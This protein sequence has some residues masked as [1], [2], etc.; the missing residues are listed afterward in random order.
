[1]VTAF[2]ELILP[3]LVYLAIMF[4][5]IWGLRGKGD[6]P[7]VLYLV[8]LAFPQIA[9]AANELPL[10]STSLSLL[11]ISSLFAAWMVKGDVPPGGASK[12]IVITYLAYVTF[13]F[14]L[15]TSV[16]GYTEIF[17]TRAWVFES[18]RNWMLTVLL[19]FVG[20]RV[21]RSDKQLSTLF[22]ILAVAL[23][24]L[25][26]REFRNFYGGSTFSYLK[27]AGETFNLRG[28]N[29]NHFAAF[30]AYLC[31]LM[32]GLFVEDKRLGRRI[33]YLAAAGA[34]LY[35]L[36]FSYSRGAYAALALAIFAVGIL[37]YRPL[38]AYGLV[39]AIFWQAI[40]PES[41]VDRVT[42]TESPDGELEESAALRLVVWN[43][44]EDVFLANPIVG[45]GFQGFFFASADLPLH[46]A[47][48]YFLQT[49]A[50]QGAIGVILLLVILL[51][52][53]WVGLTLAR[54]GETEI[55]RGLG[56]GFF[57]LTVAMATA[58]IFGDRF[59]LMEMGSYFW[60]LFGASQRLLN[61]RNVGLSGAG[62]DNSP[63]DRVASLA[64][65]TVDFRP[66]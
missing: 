30:V 20:Y 60:F 24:L 11:I 10:G 23:L 18:W 32:V 27:R 9:Q 35:P 55:K 50:E 15:I 17:V 16:Y 51:R 48:N 43:L 44:A 29:A 40:I 7:L 26:I 39:A 49:A 53:L 65:S 14:L 28:L 19:Y 12:K 46:N 2:K 25:S 62:I 54:N 34:G 13:S 3:L 36:F 57:A 6:Q 4:A 37:R 41:V 42:M 66:R 64:K 47:H 31:A 33:L 58:N 5:C 59:S 45:I 56:L 21:S 1:M 52:A 8:L 22:A 38:I 61:D 63:V